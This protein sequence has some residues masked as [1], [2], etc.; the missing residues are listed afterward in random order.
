MPKS[1]FI[2]EEA[3]SGAGIN[4]LKLQKLQGKELVERMN[5]EKAG[6]KRARIAAG[7]CD[8]SECM[9]ISDYIIDSYHSKKLIYCRY[10]EKYVTDLEKRKKSTLC[11]SSLPSQNLAS[12]TYL[13][14]IK[15]LIEEHNVED[16]KKD[17]KKMKMDKLKAND[18]GSQQMYKL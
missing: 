11:E 18:I 1:M 5:P 15:K 14:N 17:L 3:K 7:D 2:H 6:T 13:L 10:G 9:A 8:I 12:A 4:F 16:G